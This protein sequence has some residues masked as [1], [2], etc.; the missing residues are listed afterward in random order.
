MKKKDGKE[1]K[2]RKIFRCRHILKT[3]DMLPDSSEEAVVFAIIREIIILV[4]S[5]IVL[6]VI[7]FLM[8]TTA[9]YDFGRSLTNA[10]TKV[11]FS[12]YGG[13]TLSFYDIRTAND[14]WTYSE[15]VLVNALY[16]ENWYDDFNPVRKTDG[17]DN[18]VLL[19]SSVMGVARIRQLRV[20]NNSC[21]LHDYMVRNFATCYGAYSTWAE[22]NAPF[23]RRRGTA[24]T[25]STPKD[26]GSVSYY[27]TLAVYGSGGFYQ[28][29]EPSKAA[30]RSL[31][32]DLK[33]NLWLTKGTRA[34]IYEFTL[35]NANV[36]LFCT[37]KIVFE[38]PP[39]GG[40]LP[41]ASFRPAYLMRY[42]TDKRLS[43]FVFE[44]T[45]LVLLVYYTIEAIEELV[46]F[47][48]RYFKKFWNY[49]DLAF[50]LMSYATIVLSLLR[51]Y[52]TEAAL[53][54]MRAV[55]FEPEY[56]N[57][58]EATGY[59]V[60]F[61]FCMAC[62]LFIQFFKLFKYFAFNRKLGQL[63]TTLR[64][65]RNGI[66]GYTVMF[67]VVFFA[68][69]ELGY[70]LFGS[71][72]QRFC[73][74]STSMVTLF[75]TVLGDFNY[76]E[77]E[78][79]DPIFAPIFFIS[80][81]FVVFYI[82]MNMFLAIVN[83]AFADCKVEMLIGEQSKRSQLMQRAMYRILN[84]LVITRIFIPQY[85]LNPKQYY[86]TVHKAETILKAC[87][88]IEPDIMGVIS[89]C[90]GDY[91]KKKSKIDVL[92]LMKE[93]DRTVYEVPPLPDLPKKIAAANVTPIILESEFL[94]QNRRIEDIESELVDLSGQLDGLIQ[95]ISNALSG[96]NEEED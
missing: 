3:S 68:Y 32:F 19:E 15:T 20:R 28:K 37:A 93:G 40:V 52:S 27:G 29:L 69:A 72:V 58:E 83:D 14:F 54:R 25:Y 76:A 86:V 60:Q 73:G 16:S 2:W 49:I 23:G 33:V 84:R 59:Q 4:I 92:L 41:S 67:M 96:E 50:V 88:F 24:W 91:R 56:G 62:V 79:A 87:G 90:G 9:L 26:V 75:R 5:I 53:K 38:F 22:D 12:G 95:Q 13:S 35:F 30:S 65:C 47:R 17:E 7:S 78:E 57:F 48:T 42:Q 70:L 45:F 64:Y 18:N 36:D 63:N 6:S 85:I 51:Y 89:K 34:I 11:K 8:T 55:A 80:Y 77:L 44:G 74:F 71:Q 81:I 1:S 43:L 39:T 10:F 31:I 46:F 82:L 21:I 66:S 61:D 94:E